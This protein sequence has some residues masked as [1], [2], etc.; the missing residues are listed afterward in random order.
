MDI[1]V[2]LSLECLLRNFSFVGHLY[3][4]PPRQLP[5]NRLDIRPVKIEIA[6]FPG[7]GRIGIDLL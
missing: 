2:N 3:I 6:V 7:Y 4:V 1:P 5:H